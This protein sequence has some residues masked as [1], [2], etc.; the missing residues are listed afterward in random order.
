MSYE[1]VEVVEDVSVAALARIEPR[2]D[3]LVRPAADLADIA[4]AFADYQTLTKSLLDESDYQQIQ[5]KKFPKR[6]AWRKLAVAFGVTFQIVDRVHD[7][8][9]SGRILR[10]EFI[11]RAI[12]PNTRYADGWG[13]CSAFERCCPQG[14]R[15]RHNHCPAERGEPCSGTVHFTHA[16]H[17]I[18]ATAETR[19]KN[20]AAADLFG[21]GAVSAEEV[22]D[23]SGPR[24]RSS[25][26]TGGATKAT[27]A[28]VRAIHTL[29]GKAYL[30]M[31]RPSAEALEHEIKQSVGVDSFNDVSFE[32]GS[33]II[34]RLQATIADA[35]KTTTSGSGSALE[36]EGATETG[37]AG[38]VDGDDA[39]QGKT[40][41]SPP[42]STTPATTP[43]GMATTEQ[44]DRFKRYTKA[45]TRAA[46]VAQIESHFGRPL[47]EVTKDELG[48]WFSDLMKGA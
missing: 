46:A 32:V 2:M 3:S 25:G 28:M 16:E 4:Q 24:G 29:I 23:D 11:V 20:R 37:A 48:A 47:A 33:N 7:R 43:D 45:K 36:G 14:C 22:V 26:S 18:P 1:D 17:D 6:S 15:R 39:Q 31:A 9:A 35:E 40:A 44:V 34:E 12:A 5:D 21:M 30:P 27:P 42:D 13:A 10:S 41:E 19:A 8:D 38:V